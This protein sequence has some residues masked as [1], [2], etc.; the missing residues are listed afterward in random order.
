MQV[1]GKLSAL[2]LDVRSVAPASGF[3][4][5]ADVFFG[6]CRMEIRMTHNVASSYCLRR[7]RAISWKSLFH[8]MGN[9]LHGLEKRCTSS[10]KRFLHNVIRYDAALQS[11]SL[12]ARS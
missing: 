6:E 8:L 12:N 4:G 7:F 10:A 3:L 1:R 5:L 2:D 9:Y 11:P